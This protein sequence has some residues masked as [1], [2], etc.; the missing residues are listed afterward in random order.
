MRV[1]S[2]ENNKE[3]WAGRGGRGKGSDLKGPINAVIER[4]KTL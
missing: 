3:R 4:Y 1:W 2:S